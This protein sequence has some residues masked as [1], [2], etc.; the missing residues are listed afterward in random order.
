MDE[1]RHSDILR[2]WAAD[3]GPED[4]DGGAGILLEAAAALDAQAKRIKSMEDEIGHL[5]R[6]RHPSESP[7][8]VKA[9]TATAIA[10]RIA[11]LES[12][13]IPDRSQPS[14]FIEVLPM[15]S[16]LGI[17]RAQGAELTEDDHG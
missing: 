3:I 16:A 10:K 4:D 11:A 8:E 9:R 12:V 6:R 15:T 1:I 7:S 14:G 13:K 2:E 5:H 17:C